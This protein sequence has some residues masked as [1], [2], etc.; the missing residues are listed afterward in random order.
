MCVYEL[1]V[2]V[3][4]KA[5]HLNIFKNTIK[6]LILWG[7]Q[8]N[9]NQFLHSLLSTSIPVS[10]LLTL[11]SPSACDVRSPGNTGGQ[12]TSCFKA[13]R[14]L[15]G[16]WLPSIFIYLWKVSLKYQ[17]YVIVSGI[18]SMPPKWICFKI[19]E[20]WLTLFIHFSETNSVANTTRYELS[21]WLHFP[22]LQWHPY[23]WHTT[24]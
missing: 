5:C 11:C 20:F 16:R 15:F 23:F 7:S 2:S 3:S 10:L 14:L 22:H 17:A 6:M 1:C 18:F 4:S 8:N 21:R 12:E 19:F 9:E 13:S 24:E